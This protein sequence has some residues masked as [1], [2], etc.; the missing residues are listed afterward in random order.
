MYR[1]INDENGRHYQVILT[2]DLFGTWTLIASWGARDSRHGGAKRTS[3][4]SRE[5]GLAR[6]KEID[7]RRRRNGYRL[8]RGKLPDAESADP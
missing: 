3:L 8:V 2:Q 4:P 5:A 6:L 1:W 7:R